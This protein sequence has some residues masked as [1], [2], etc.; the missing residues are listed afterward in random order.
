MKFLSTVL[1]ILLFASASFSQDLELE[2]KR[3]ILQVETNYGDFFIRLFTKEAPITCKNFLDYVNDK[4]YDN[5]IIHRVIPGFIIQGGGFE[6]GLIPKPFNAPIQNESTNKNSKKNLKGTLGMALNQRK[7]SAA[8][9]FYIN[10]AD[11]PDLD[12][13]I[14]NVRGHTVFAEIISGMDVIEK[15]SKVRTRKLNY[16]SELYDMVIIFESY[17]ENEIIIKK[18]KR[19]NN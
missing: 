2:K 10:L 18:I 5:T 11:N 14:N 4:Y 17:P 3:T 16:K 1:C 7:A 9:Q 19:L 6:R 13:S 8:S 15:I 12:Y